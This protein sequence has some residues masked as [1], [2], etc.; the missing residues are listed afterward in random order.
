MDCHTQIEVAVAIQEA[1][2]IVVEEPWRHVGG[3][4]DEVVEMWLAEDYRS[5]VAASLQT[6]F[7]HDKEETG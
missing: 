1:V 2:V 4:D 3:R 6:A 5:L 7:Y